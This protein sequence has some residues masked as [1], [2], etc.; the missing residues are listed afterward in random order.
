M[1]RYYAFDFE[2]F[3]SVR[4]YRMDDDQI[5]RTYDQAFDRV[6]NIGISTL[7]QDALKYLIDEMEILTKEELVENDLLL[8]N[9]KFEEFDSPNGTHAT[10]YYNVEVHTKDMGFGVELETRYE[11]IMNPETDETQ[12]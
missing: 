2:I 6:E 3:Y 10:G 12:D 8:T 11:N 4:D 5:G 1:D 9:I 7:R